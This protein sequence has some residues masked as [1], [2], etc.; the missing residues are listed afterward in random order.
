M[1][2]HSALVAAPRVATPGDAGAISE[3][4]VDAFANDQ[5]SWSWWAFPDPAVCGQQRRAVFRISSR[6]HCGT[7]GLADRRW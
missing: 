4:L 6:G 2:Q 3:L 5:M 7:G 1:S